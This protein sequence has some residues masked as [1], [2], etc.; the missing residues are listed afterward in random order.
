LIIAV[1]CSQRGKKRR[2]RGDM[3]RDDGL[4]EVDVEGR[5]ERNEK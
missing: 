4:F 2:K 5:G 3:Q 1:K